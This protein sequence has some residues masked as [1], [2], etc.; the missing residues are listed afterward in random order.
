MKGDIKID[1]IRY[2]IFDVLRKIKISKLTL[3]RVY[4]IDRF[5]SKA[6]IS[7]SFIVID[8][9]EDFLITLKGEEVTVYV[10]DSIVVENYNNGYAESMFEGI[11]VGSL[12]IVDVGIDSKIKG[13]SKCFSADRINGIKDILY[14]LDGLIECFSYSCINEINID[15]INKTYSSISSTFEDCD[16]NILSMRNCVLKT[17]EVISPFKKCSIKTLDVR[18]SIIEADVINEILSE[19]KI[20]KIDARGVKLAGKFE[21]GITRRCEIRLLDISNADFSNC[22]I[23]TVRLEKIGVIN[24]I[25]AYNTKISMSIKEFIKGTSIMSLETNMEYIRQAWICSKQRH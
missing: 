22:R 12:E 17:S 20:D 13:M 8:V 23:G 21:V 11:C 15:G 4:D 19:A 10:R 16:I 9:D 6:M 24:K 14:R 2:T 18:D 7:N 5:T 3:R 1:G 25:I